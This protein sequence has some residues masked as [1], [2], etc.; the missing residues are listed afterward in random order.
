MTY[1]PTP[2]PATAVDTLTAAFLFPRADVDPVLDTGS[3]TGLAT[4]AA[5]AANGAGAAL[6][7]VNGGQ[8]AAAGP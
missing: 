7:S 8:D 3:A 1:R 6:P 4:R 5:A 2:G